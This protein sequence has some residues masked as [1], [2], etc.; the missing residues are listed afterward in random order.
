M[1]VRI[2]SNVL[3]LDLRLRSD[4]NRVKAQWYNGARPQR[5]LNFISRILKSV[6]N[7]TW[8][9]QRDVKTGVSSCFL[10]LVNANHFFLFI[11]KSQI[12]FQT[13]PLFCSSWSLLDWIRHTHGCQSSVRLIMRDMLPSVFPHI[14]KSWIRFS[15]VNVP[16]LV[17]LT[18]PTCKDWNLLNN[19]RQI[20]SSFS[21][22]LIPGRVSR[23]GSKQNISEFS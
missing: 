14:S 13:A 15:A 9:Q 10:V 1:D 19:S 6:L 18:K 23:H 22:K 3:F 16:Q 11:Y 2:T 7:F 21:S 8:N 4:S 17:M 5:A 12:Y 20:S